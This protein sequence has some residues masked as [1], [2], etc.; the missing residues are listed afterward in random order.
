MFLFEIEIVDK[1]V[2]GLKKRIYV[3]LGLYQVENL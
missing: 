2:A 1:S 3:G